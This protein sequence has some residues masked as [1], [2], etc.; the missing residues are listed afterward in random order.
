MELAASIDRYLCPTAAFLDKA[1]CDLFRTSQAE[2][3]EL[4]DSNKSALRW[5]LSIHNPKNRLAS[6][7][8]TKTAKWR[9]DGCAS[10]GRRFFALPIFMLPDLPPRRIDVL[11]P[12]QSQQAA[13]L[14]RSLQS[15]E[16]FNTSSTC[17]EHLGISKYIARALENWSANQAYFREYSLRYLLD[18]A[19][20]LKPSYL[21]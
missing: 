20:S 5:S 2:Y 3:E 8:V 18:R 10:Q 9:I 17:V 14:R 7:E 11:I 6:L 21:T 13:P 1:G 15:S 19:S 4:Q 16:A 12:C